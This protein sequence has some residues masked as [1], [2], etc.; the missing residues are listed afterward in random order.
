LD[1]D[2]SASTPRWP[3]RQGTTSLCTGGLHCRCFLHGASLQAMVSQEYAICVLHGG[4][5]YPCRP[6]FWSCGSIISICALLDT[7]FGVS[8]YGPT[9]KR[10][11]LV[12]DDVGGVAV[13][14]GCSVLPF[15]YGG[16]LFVPRVHV[17]ST[18][19]C[20]PPSLPLDSIV[21]GFYRPEQDQVMGMVSCTTETGLTTL[22]RIPCRIPTR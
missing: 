1:V 3:G 10:T 9:K 6:G 2:M 20:R 8:R 4:C 11:V 16:T 7:S 19:C 17:L 13:N 22:L 14:S 18:I 21:R 15:C 5:N 12:V